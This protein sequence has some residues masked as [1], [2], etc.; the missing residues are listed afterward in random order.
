MPVSSF[1]DLRQ[2]E[3][4]PVHVDRLHAALQIAAGSAFHLHDP[5]PAQVPRTRSRHRFR[6]AAVVLGEEH[7]GAHGPLRALLW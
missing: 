7:P 5:G 2:V 4:S 1:G 3:G 6:D